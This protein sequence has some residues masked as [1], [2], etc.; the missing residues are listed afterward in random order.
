MLLD[1]PDHVMVLIGRNFDQENCR[2]ALLACL[3]E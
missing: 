1:E 3:A 2:A